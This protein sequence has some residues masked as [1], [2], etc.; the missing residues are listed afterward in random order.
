MLRKNLLPL[1]LTILAIF[2]FVYWQFI[3][4]PFQEE[5]A[6]IRAENQKFMAIEHELI[7]FKTRHEDV[8]AY[9]E[10]TNENLHE[11][12]RSLPDEIADAEFVDALYRIAESNRILI[13]SAQVGSISADDSNNVQRQSINVNLEGDY[14]SLLNF[15]REVLDGERLAYLAN[16]SMTGN[17]GFLNC[18]LEFLIYAQMKN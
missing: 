6:S 2:A 1:F 15:I 13:N 18:N 9:A 5:M 8:E 12:R 4:I 14:V 11:A 16:V 10:L 7:E 3:Y 17:G